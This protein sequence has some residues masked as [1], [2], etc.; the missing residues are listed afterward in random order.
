MI[1]QISRLFGTIIILFFPL[2]K[3][4]RDFSIL[5]IVKSVVLCAMIAV[6]AVKYF[7]AGW[8]LMIMAVMGLTKAVATFPIVFSSI[9]MF[10]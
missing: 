7:K 8:L 6:S 3:L 2:R 1:R 5:T 4:K 9:N 10:I